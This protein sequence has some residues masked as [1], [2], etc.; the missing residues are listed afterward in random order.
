V[1]EQAG[2]MWYLKKINLFETLDD[3]I[4]EKLGE[5]THVQDVPEGQPIYFPGDTADTIFMLKKGRVRLSRSGQDGRNITLTIL[6]PGDV[7]GEMALT[8]EQERDT[9][10]ETMS[11]AFICSA[12]REKFLE[13]VRDNPELNMKITGMIGDRKRNIEARIQNLIFRDSGNRVAYVL[14]DLFENHSETNDHTEPAIDFTHEQI[15][16][17]AGLTRPTTTNILNDLQN[18]GIIELSR[19]EITLKEPN[20]LSSRAEAE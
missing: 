8:G 11:N 4:M 2:K 14:H 17:L 1:N 15:A 20:R 3:E 13:V 5:I 12:P 10:A 18:D 16:D 6:E 9:R 7:F 19:K